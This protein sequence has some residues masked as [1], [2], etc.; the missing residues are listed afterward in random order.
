MDNGAGAA[1]HHLV[2]PGFEWF[3][4]AGSVVGLGTGIPGNA[5]KASR[6]SLLPWVRDEAAAAPALPV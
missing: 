1:A 6:A 2:C 3:F 4:N 5:S